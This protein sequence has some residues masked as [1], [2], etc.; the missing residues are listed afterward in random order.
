[1]ATIQELRE[2]ITVIDNQIAKL[3]QD[4]RELRDE[5]K[6]AIQ[7]SFEAEHG[8]KH[9]DPIK[10]RGGETM[11]YDGFVFDAFGNIVILCHATKKDGTASKTIHH[12][13]EC[14][15]DWAEQRKT[16]LNS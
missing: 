4:R 10:T 8:V 5:L 6:E 9:G 7:A 2:K 3:K 1:M 12:R 16:T 13:Y 11:F 14:D 15:F